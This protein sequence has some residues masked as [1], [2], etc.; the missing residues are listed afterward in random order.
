MGI[1]K[2]PTQRSYYSKNCILYTPFFPETLPFERLELILRFL[3]FNDNTALNEYKG[4]SKLF[5]IYP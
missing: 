5:E 3:H 4:P 2:K 1:V